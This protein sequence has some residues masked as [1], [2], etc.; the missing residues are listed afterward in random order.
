MGVAESVKDSLS[1]AVRQT[2]RG[3]HEVSRGTAIP[4]DFKAGSGPGRPF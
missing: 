2:F 4:P 3:P 1:H